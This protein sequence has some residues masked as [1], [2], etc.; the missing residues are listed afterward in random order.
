MSRPRY[1]ICISG[2]AKG[3]D[4]RLAY[5]LARAVAVQIVE[6]GHVV[7]TGATKALPYAAAKAAKDVKSEHITS[8]GFSPAATKL[9][10][11]KK[12]LLPTDAFDLIVYT[13]FEYTGR[14]LLLVRS[15]DAVVMVGGRIG[16]LNEFTIALEEKKPIGVLMGS[17]GM[18]NE[19]QRVLKTAHRGRT[20]I[21]FD[22]NPATLV[23][24]LIDIVNTKYRKIGT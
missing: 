14:N 7:I 4:E 17:G 16:T 15:A 10:H 22:E 9:A 1:Q 24:R 20:N 21:I 3:V 8:I 13:G 5:G 2:A 18:T 11:V 6:Q 19:V 23:T 12:Y